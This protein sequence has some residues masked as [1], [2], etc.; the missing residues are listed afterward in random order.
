MTKYGGALLDAA[1]EKYGFDAEK[2]KMSLIYKIEHKNKVVELSTMM[3]E[4]PQEPNIK[5]KSKTQEKIDKLFKPD[6]NGI[7]EW[8]K[9][10]MINEIDG[11][12]WGGN[13]VFRNGTFRNDKRYI[14]EKTPQSG[15]IKEIRT[16]GF[17]EDYLYGHSRPIRPDI[18]AYYKTKKCVACG[19]SSD[20]VTDH[21]N[22]LYN[23]IRVLDNK[24]QT[25]EDFQCLCNHCN[26]QKR[27]ISKKTR[28]TG[29]RYGATNIPS[30]AVFGIDYIEGNETFDK[31]DI[32]AMVGT[33]WYDPVKFMTYIKTS[34][35]S[36]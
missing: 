27:E 19:S 14:W 29:K 34:L 33:Y 36:Q 8:I 28:E 10:E 25:K 2:A 7:S 1:G 35:G 11:L 21:K 5:K 4:S 31:D 18:K 32:N 12:K 13:G 20:L 22:D 30:I 9:T 15:A 17:S 6:E 24:T 3:S 26:L 23:D 16:A